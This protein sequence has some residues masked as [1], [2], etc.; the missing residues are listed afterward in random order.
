ML[1][2][3]ACDSS[4]ASCFP[5]NPKCMSCLPGTALHHGKCISQCPAH[6]YLDTHS[7]CR[8]RLNLQHLQQFFFFFFFYFNIV[9]HLKHKVAPVAAS[10]LTR[11]LPSL[12]NSF[13]LVLFLGFG[14]DLCHLTGESIKLIYF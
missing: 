3:T 10:I 14:W 7:R 12:L 6:N 2:F 1:W 11:H 4:C 9:C 13:H 8:G 5:D